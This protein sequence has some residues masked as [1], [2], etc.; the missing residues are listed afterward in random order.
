MKILDITYFF[1]YFY[2]SKISIRVH[3]HTHY[4]LKLSFEP[5]PL[6]IAMCFIYF[7]EQILRP[8]F[9]VV[10]NRFKLSAIQE[11]CLI[12]MLPLAAAFYVQLG[13]PPTNEC[14]I[15]PR[16]YIT[17]FIA[18]GSVSRIICNFPAVKMLPCIQKGFT[19]WGPNETHAH[20]VLVCISFCTGCPFLD[21]SYNKENCC[22]NTFTAALEVYFHFQL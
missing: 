5:Y 18:V 19:I 17:T 10:S 20:Q 21:A 9:N 1:F 2:L 7:K 6:F 11:G 15:L 22:L 4:T 12:F 13:F 16:L 3:P 14:S 8:Y